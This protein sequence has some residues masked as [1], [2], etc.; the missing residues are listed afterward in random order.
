MH[1][2]GLNL[3]S[4]LRPLNVG[5]RLNVGVSGVPSTFYV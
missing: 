4:R 2:H 5:P 3:K 1:A